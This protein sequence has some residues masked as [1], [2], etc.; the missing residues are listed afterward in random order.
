M[1]DSVV[2]SEWNDRDTGSTHTEFLLKVRF[3]L[4]GM[5]ENVIGEAVLNAQSQ[6]IKRRILATPF[7]EM[8]IV[9]SENNFLAE[10]FVI[11]RQERTIEGFTFVVPQDMK[12][13]R[14]GF[15]SVEHECRV[16]FQN[17]RDF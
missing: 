11:E 9:R 2:N 13:F 12:D 3:H 15:S 16:V 7:G 5:N 17:P 6:A 4:F 8:H 10:E 1:R 14:F